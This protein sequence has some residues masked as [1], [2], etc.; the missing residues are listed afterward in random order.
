[1]KIRNALDS[2]RRS[3]GEPVSRI[4]LKIDSLYTALYAMSQ[5]HKSDKEVADLVLK[6]KIYLVGAFVNSQA[7]RMLIMYS[8]ERASK[9]RNLTLEEIIQFINKIEQNVHDAGLTNTVNMPKGGNVLDTIQ[10]G[11]QTI[12]SFNFVDANTITGVFASSFVSHHGTKRQQD[13][14]FSYNKSQ[15]PFGLLIILG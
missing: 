10:S 9:G 8:R 11:G 4:L 12:N 3:P 1:M 6:H 15:V 7:L 14:R 13:T 2:L 5:P